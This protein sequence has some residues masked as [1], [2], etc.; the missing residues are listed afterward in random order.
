MRQFQLV[1]QQELDKVT[2]AAANAI[3]Q[4]NNHIQNG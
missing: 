3:T 1:I 2:T 4:L